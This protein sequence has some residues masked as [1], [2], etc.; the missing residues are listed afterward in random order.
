M[1]WMKGV[2]TS[3]RLGIPHHGG[4]E[5]QRHLLPGMSCRRQGAQSSPW[6][7]KLLSLVLWQTE[8]QGGELTVLKGAGP[9]PRILLTYPVTSGV[10]TEV[11]LFIKLL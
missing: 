6:P 10:N 8:E 7:S 1:M 2:F 5:A 4:S 9:H 11:C 3:C